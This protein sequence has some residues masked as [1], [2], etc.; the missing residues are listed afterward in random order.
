MN[1]Y[2]HRILPA[3]G[4]ITSLL[5]IHFEDHPRVKAFFAKVRSNKSFLLYHYRNEF[6]LNTIYG[7][8]RI[9]YGFALF[10][11]IFSESFSFLSE[12]RTG[13]AALIV[14]SVV[15]DFCTTL[16]ISKYRNFSSEFKYLLFDLGPRAVAAIGAA[17]IPYANAHPTHGIS[18]P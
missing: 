3:I 1:I 14:F 10:F 16:Y 13:Y 17:Y 7:F 8:T 4:V 5:I 11:F 9:M 2:F 12:N 18:H 6:V 15:L